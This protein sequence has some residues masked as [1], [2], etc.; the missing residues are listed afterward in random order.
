MESRDGVPRRH[1]IWSLAARAAFS[2][3]RGRVWSSAGRVL[4]S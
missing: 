1:W 2:T 3:V 4:E